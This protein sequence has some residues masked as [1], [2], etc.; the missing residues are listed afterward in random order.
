MAGNEDLP[1][2]LA[3]CPILS[4]IG[5]GK[6]QDLEFQPNG[7]YTDMA[8]PE[9]GG[10]QV[11]QKGW[12]LEI[13]MELSPDAINVQHLESLRIRQTHGPVH[14]G[15]RDFEK[16]DVAAEI[17]DTRAIDIGPTDPV[18]DGETFVWQCGESLLFGVV[19]Q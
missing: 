13:E 15:F 6:P 10:Q 4:I 14:L 3:L 1:L 11:I 7:A 8:H 5:I 2:D 16:A 19:A 12:G 9:L 17:D 18:L